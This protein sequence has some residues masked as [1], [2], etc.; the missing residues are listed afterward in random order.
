MSDDTTPRERAFQLALDHISR[1]WLETTRSAEI[2]RRNGEPFA[3]ERD[4][5]VQLAKLHNKMLDQSKLD[6]QHLPQRPI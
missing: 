5:A 6:G 1:T 2:A 4:V 3:Y